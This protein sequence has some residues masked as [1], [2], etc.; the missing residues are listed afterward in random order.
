MNIFGIISEY[1]P[2]HMGH[3]HHIDQTRALLGEDSGVICVMSGNFVQRGEAAAFTKNARAECAIRGGA[4]LVLEL[5]LPWA[6]SSAEGFARGAVG[7]LDACGVVSH[8]SFG[9]ESGNV[10]V[11]DD[12]A[13]LLLAPELDA[14]IR[15][16]L[17]EGVSYASARQMAA[18]KLAGKALPEMKSPNNILG[19]EYI[20]ALYDLRSAIKP[21]TIP[22]IGAGHDQSGGGDYPSASELRKR[23]GRGE[24]VLSNMPAECTRVLEREMHNGRGPVMGGSLD[25]AI[26]SRLRMLP[27]ETYEALPDGGEGLG[28]RLCRA[29]KTEVSVDAVIAAAATKRYALSRLRRMI[30]CASLGIKSGAGDG[31]PP[32]IRVL[33]ANEKGCAI[34]KKMKEKASLPVITKPAEINS[35]DREAKECFALE[36]SAT[37]LFVLGFSAREERKGDRDYR[38][39]PA[40]IK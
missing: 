32:Y 29:A 13:K 31:L 15:D 12:I 16:N 38:I 11:L 8:I 21:V 2:F 30:M 37:D 10:D 26:I 23:L 19:I 7:I 5:P 20:K 18:E 39:S 1:N 3:K 14:I 34:L 4:D 36:S 35:L 6:I 40:I 9:S 24:S 27:S 25:T 28:L 22:R 17:S 33:A